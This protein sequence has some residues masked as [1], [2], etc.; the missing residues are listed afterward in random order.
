[1]YNKK[2]FTKAERTAIAKKAWKTRILNGTDKGWGKKEYKFNNEGDHKK[3]QREEKALAYKNSGVINGN[4]LFL[5]SHTCKDMTV[6]NKLLPNNKYNFIG[7][8]NNKKVIKVLLKRINKENL[9]LSIYPKSISEIVK[10]SPEDN[11]AHIDFDFC[12]TFSKNKETLEYAIKNNIVKTNGII[13][14]TFSARDLNIGKV[15][16]KILGKT[17]YKR[18]KENKTLG[19][20]SVN[21][22]VKSLSKNYIFI[23]E[24][25]IYRESKKHNPMIFAMIQR[26]K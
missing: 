8:E 1:M 23:N 19:I 24:P 5:P 17:Q 3:A 10:S 12:E 13:S 11:F 20:T 6:I 18:C 4:L 15:A 9:N 26:V 21:K 14:L 25:H 7:A 16:K 2:L 22:F